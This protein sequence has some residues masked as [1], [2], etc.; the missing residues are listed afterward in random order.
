MLKC[1]VVRF[2]LETPLLDNVTTGKVSQ[3]IFTVFFGVEQSAS[4][5]SLVRMLITSK[6]VFAIDIP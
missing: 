5:S 4:I 2:I 6:D 3:K 1:T